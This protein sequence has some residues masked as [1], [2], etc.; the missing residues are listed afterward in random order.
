[1]VNSFTFSHSAASCCMILISIASREAINSRASLHAWAQ[2]SEGECTF[3]AQLTQHTL[4]STRSIFCSRCHWHWAWAGCLTRSTQPS[5]GTVDG[6]QLS[7]LARSQRLTGHTA[8]QWCLHPTHL[9]F[10]TCPWPNPYCCSS[11]TGVS[12]QA[13]KRVLWPRDAI[14]ARSRGAIGTRLH[15][16]CVHA[17]TLAHPRACQQSRT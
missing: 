7:L 11:L 5:H 17:D 8:P 13:L 1:M 6:S 10:R 14:Q 15:I 4:N 2:D 12:S 16:R 9:A 3:S